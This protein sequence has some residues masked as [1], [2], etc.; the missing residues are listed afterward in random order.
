MSK[1]ALII[2][3][4]FIPIQLNEFGIALRD[5]IQLLLQLVDFLDELFENISPLSIV[6][7][8][9]LFLPLVLVK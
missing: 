4:S 3:A 6:C 7:P 5:D 1:N 8:V 2:S 9:L